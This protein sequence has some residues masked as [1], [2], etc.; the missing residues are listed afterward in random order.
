MS[1]PRATE[2]I[3][4]KTD[5]AWW[6]TRNPVATWWQTWWRQMTTDETKWKLMIAQD[7]AWACSWC[8]LFVAEFV[9]DPRSFILM[10]QHTTLAQNFGNQR[11]AIGSHVALSARVMCFQSPL[12]GANG[13]ANDCASACGDRFQESIN[14]CHLTFAQVS[15]FVSFLSV[16]SIQAHSKWHRCISLP[17]GQFR[18]PGMRPKWS[19]TWLFVVFHLRS[20]LAVVRMRL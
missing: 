13:C 2:D 1:T 8:W 10:L 18:W 14:F 9:V 17:S 11:A 15:G 16:W 19:G 3:L 12:V 6:K 7:N 20:F 4:I 5:E